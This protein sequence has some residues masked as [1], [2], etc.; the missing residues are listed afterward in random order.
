MNL[1][2][3]SNVSR[4]CNSRHVKAD[5]TSHRYNTAVSKWTRGPFVEWV[6]F[7][8]IWYLHFVWV[9]GVMLCFNH[10]IT[11]FPQYVPVKEKW[12]SV[13][14][15]R[16]CGRKFA[17]HCLGS[18]C[19]DWCR[20]IVT[21]DVKSSMTSWPRGQN[22]V[23]GLGLGLDELSSASASKV[24]A[25]LTSRIVTLQ[26]TWRCRRSRER[27][28]T[29]AWS[30]TESRTCWLT[31]RR[32]HLWDTSPWLRSLLTRSHIRS[33]DLH[34]PT[35]N[36]LLTLWRPLLPYGYSYKASCDRPG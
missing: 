5:R 20:M 31:R 19:S 7:D 26:I 28:R 14:I 22:F 30:R 32:P 3:V 6:W 11:N 24:C 25:R 8:L 15:W 34:S 21:S 17:A 29:G 13:S 1:N 10:S 33:L 36:P 27:W 2:N 35:A 9:I 23:L 12:N 16:Q 18:P 4:K